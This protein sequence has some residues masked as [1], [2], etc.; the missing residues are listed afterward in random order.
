MI[1]NRQLTFGFTKVPQLTELQIKTMWE[2]YS[3]YYDGCTF[4]KF[5]K[6]LKEKQLVIMLYDRITGDLKGFSTQILKEIRIGEKWCRILFSGDT[7]I[8]KE[9]WGQKTLQMAFT[10]MM[11]KLKL[12]KP[13]SPL[14]WFLI[15][16]G[17]KTYLLLSNNFKRFWPRYDQS[18]PA[19]I[20]E[21]MDEY[22]SLYFPDSYSKETG[23]L[24]FEKGEHEHLKTG[25]AEITEKD[26]ENPNISFF[27]QSNPLW[28]RGDELVCIG[29]FDLNF[30]FRLLIKTIRRKLFSISN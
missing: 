1:K 17:F 23:L 6:D 13:M 29:E 16:K 10:M 26:L 24:V 30:I 22:A 21:I 7:V 4:D 20:K 15:T 25:V 11:L 18:T 14:Y 8:E 2:L 12:Q 19:F 27:T 3:R 5:L 28:R 9:Y